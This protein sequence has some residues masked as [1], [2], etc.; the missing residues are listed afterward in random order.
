MGGPL[1][2][3]WTC[4]LRKRPVLTQSRLWRCGISGRARG[5]PRGSS[6]CH[7]PQWR[8]ASHSPERSRESTLAGR[9]T[10][11]AP[12]LH[13]YIGRPD[14]SRLSPVHF[15]SAQPQLPPAPIPTPLTHTSVPEDSPPGWAVVAS[16]GASPTCLTSLPTPLTSRR[17]PTSRDKATPFPPGGRP[18]FLSVSLSDLREPHAAILKSRTHLCGAGVGAATTH[19]QIAAPGS[20]K[21]APSTA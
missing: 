7:P 20:C 18:P 21:L 2:G 13:L 8:G 10:T 3:E 9:A 4:S 19:P 17:P 14:A 12:H 6:H 5:H 15:A 11:H 1:M 16:N